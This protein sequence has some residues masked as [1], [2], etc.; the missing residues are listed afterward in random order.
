M[1]KIAI[2]RG[3]YER[4]NAVLE[5]HNIKLTTGSGGCDSASALAELRYLSQTEYEQIVKALQPPA[6][7]W[8]GIKVLICELQYYWQHSQP[9]VYRVN[10]SNCPVD[11]SSFPV[12]N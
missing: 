3:T 4:L 5:T 11:L 12:D 6:Q 8:E 1:I 7:D 9:G 10:K 2:P